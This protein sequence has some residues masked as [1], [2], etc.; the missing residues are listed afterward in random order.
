MTTHPLR[1]TVV[2]LALACQGKDDPA[3]EDGSTPPTDSDTDTDTDA[4]SDSDTDTDTDSDSDTDTDSDSDTDTDTD[5]DTDTDTD[6]DTDTDTD[7]DTAPTG[8][9]GPLVPSASC[10]LTSD[11]VLRAWCDVNIDPPQ[12]VSVRFAKATGGPE[13]VHHSD[14]IQATHQIGLYIMESETDYTWQVETDAGPVPGMSGTLTTGTLPIDATLFYNISGTSSAQYVL[15]Q[16]PCVNTGMVFVS[17]TQGKVVWYHNM[18]PLAAFAAVDGVNWTPTNTVLSMAGEGIVEV[19]WMGNELFWAE[20]LQHFAERIHHDV[21]R[22]GDITYGLFNE[23]VTH[24][25]DTYTLDGFYAFD[26]DSNVVGEW[27][28]YDHFQPPGPDP[29][30]GND[31]SHANAILVED[32][33]ATLSFRHMSTVVQVDADPYSPTFGEVLWRLEGDPSDAHW[34]SDYTVASSAGLT[35]TIEKQH[36]PNFGPDG[37]LYLFDNRKDFQEPSRMLRIELDDTSGVADIAEAYSVPL[38][39]DF[40]GGAWQAPNGNPMPTCAPLRTAY[41]F[42]QGAAVHHWSLQASCAAGIDIYLPRY[43]P[44]EP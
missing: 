34:G 29:T 3:G 18:A 26:A 30:V 38:H 44:V 31:Y 15:H 42:A 39:C 2:V 37:S 23:S 43:V 33:I 12:P 41:E 35:P 17:D 14:A 1:F 28:L 4:D 25:N 5:S 13:R 21:G 16:S 20:R 9:T 8:D 40:Q 11:N 6:S 10:T 36:N 22:D 27:H 19:D 32:G 24:N 7:T